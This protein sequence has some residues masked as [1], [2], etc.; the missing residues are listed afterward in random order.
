MDEAGDKLDANDK[1]AS[2]SRLKC[3][4]GTCCRAADA[5]EHDRCIRLMKL[6]LQKKS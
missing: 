2:R 4:K 1:A 5:E 6:R 3:I